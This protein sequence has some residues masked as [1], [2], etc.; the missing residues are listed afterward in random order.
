MRI[1]ID[2][3]ISFTDAYILLYLSIYF[4]HYFGNFSFN[5]TYSFWVMTGLAGFFIVCDRKSEY[6]DYTIRLF[7]I[8]L[9]AAI[10]LIVNRNRSP[11]TVL[12]L[13]V[14]QMFGIYL[15]KYR[16]NL[17]LVNRI[18]NLMYIYIVL[19]AILIPPRLV[20]ASQGIYSTRFSRL[21]GGNTISIFLIMFLSIGLIYKIHNGRKKYFIFIISLFVAYR[22]GGNGGVL[23]ISVFLIGLIT[24]QWDKNKI[25]KKRM[26]LIVILGYGLI[27]YLGYQQRLWNF[28]T[29][30]NSRF[31]IWSKYL[32]CMT[33]SVKDFL[34]G[35]S[36]DRYSF[37]AEQRN[38][39]NTFFNLHYYYGIVPAIY[40]IVMIISLLI[41]S[42][43]KRNYMLLVILGV[44][45]IRGMTDETAFCFIS[46]WTYAY[47]SLKNDET[48]VFRSNI[49]SE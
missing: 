8:D 49:I 46:L 35:A 33:N 47:L 3:K 43:K 44:T 17:R 30:D 21:V 1:K 12:M 10:G 42:I 23:S 11:F 25:S 2:E 28:L 5:I 18:V 15:Y 38:M 34:F 4:V 45:V 41:L 27:C 16:K 29:D 13:P 6:S 40:Y 48:S 14:S 36:V 9:F 39:H 31:W 37:L 32:E 24:L 7:L 19:Y 22:C 26:L 20:S